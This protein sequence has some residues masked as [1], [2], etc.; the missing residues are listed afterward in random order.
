[1]AYDLSPWNRVGE[2]Y[3]LDMSEAPSGKI[4][5]S[6]APLENLTEESEKYTTDEA[7]A[8]QDPLEGCGEYYSYDMLL[9]PYVLDR[10]LNRADIIGM[11]ADE[12][13]LLRNQFY[14]I[15]GR[16]FD[17][18][19]LRD[20]FFFFSWYIALISPSEFDDSVFTLLEK[21]NIEF[22]KAIEAE[23][24]EDPEYYDKKVKEEREAL[25][26][27]EEAPYKELIPDYGEV[28]VEIYS[29]PRNATDKGIYYEANGRIA[30]PVSVTPEQYI[31]V[32]ENNGEAEVIINE[33]TGEKRIMRRCEIPNYGD[34]VLYD[35]DNSSEEGMSYFLAYEPH[36][37]HYSL[38]HNSAD[39]IFKDAYLG[40][41]Y[42]MK[43]AE[44]EYGNYFP[45]QKNSDDENSPAGGWRHMDF[46]EEDVSMTSA[47]SGNAPEFNEKGYLL[48]LY[49]WGD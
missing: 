3:K 9:M 21:R 45:L 39:T 15:Y 48:G 44:E 2:R 7:Y 1:M 14:A 46:D 25:D 17:T 8:E 47:Y 18:E 27:L 30:L 16:A 31:E 5:I 32:I 19:S 11:T 34:C 38:W 37:G 41:I 40:K 6:Y 26:A 43:G 36:L 42:V 22:L 10:P 12:L 28:Y 35:P 20:Y 13:K 4:I 29:D 24:S 23:Y 49:Y 33:L